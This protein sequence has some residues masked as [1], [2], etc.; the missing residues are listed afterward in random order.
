[1]MI[2][3]SPLIAVLIMVES[4]GNDL[5]IGDN[6]NSVGCLQIQKGVIE[7]VNKIYTVTFTQEDGTNRSSSKEICQ[8]YLNYWVKK[9]YISTEFPRDKTINVNEI[10]ARICNG[11]PNGFKKNSTIKYWNKVKRISKELGYDLSADNID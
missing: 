10:A 6:G 5:A 1:M 9:A 2:D 11:G 8:Y 3:F 7:D 4:S